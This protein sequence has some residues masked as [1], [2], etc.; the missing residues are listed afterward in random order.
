MG[1]ANVLRVRLIP[2]YLCN[3]LRSVCRV[4]ILFVF[5]CCCD[6]D[7]A[8]MF[9]CELTACDVERRVDVHVD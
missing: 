1:D 3:L 7:S 6:F 5:C 9:N 8:L 4:Q 2:V